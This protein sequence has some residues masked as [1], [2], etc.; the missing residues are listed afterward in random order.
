MSATITEQ[1]RIKNAR[2]FIKATKTDNPLYV[3]M[4]KTT[5]WLST[6]PGEEGLNIDREPML[7]EVSIRETHHDLW[8]DIYAGARVKENDVYHVIRKNEW[9]ASDTE[10]YYPYNGNDPDMA[11]TKFHTVVVDNSSIRVYKLIDRPNGQLSTYKPV[12][13]TADIPA[14]G[15]TMYNPDNPN[16]IADNDLINVVGDDEYIWKYMYTIPVALYSE[17]LNE[18]YIPVI[19]SPADMSNVA[20][21]NPTGQFEP[22]PE[23]GHGFDNVAELFAY[24]VG[25]ISKFRYNEGGLIPAKNE[26][27]KIGLIEKPLDFT[28]VAGS[29]VDTGNPVIGTPANRDVLTLASC[30][31]NVNIPVESV[32]VG[33]EMNVGNA[34]IIGQGIIVGYDEEY[35]RLYFHARTGKITQG[36]TVSLDA[37]GQTFTAGTIDGPGANKYSGN[38]LYTE[39]RRPVYRAGNQTEVITIII[40]F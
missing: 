35:S 38:T 9:V 23:G 26:F 24:S 7:P 6:Q 34:G 1:F 19:E 22:I 37:T 20:T 25:I 13:T 28:G 10:E 31:N 5:P 12:H 8:N 17:F 15:D 2:D 3:V 21:N 11:T 27:R 29:A 4:G 40:E 14:I 16:A 36:D 18:F 33:S 30:I 32:I 39:Y